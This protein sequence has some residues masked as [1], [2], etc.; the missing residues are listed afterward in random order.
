MVLLLT[1]LVD[2]TKLVVGDYFWV[3]E[4]RLYLFF[5]GGSMDKG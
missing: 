1:S 5:I 3:D 2:M 4:N